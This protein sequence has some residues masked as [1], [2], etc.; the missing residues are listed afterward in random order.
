MHTALDFKTLI[1][2]IRWLL[3]RLQEAYKYELRSN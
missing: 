2:L 1:C 3:E